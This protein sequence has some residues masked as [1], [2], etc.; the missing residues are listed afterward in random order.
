MPQ[1]LIHC[2]VIG[3]SNRE[4]ELQM[5]QTRSFIGYSD[6]DLRVVSA[7]CSEDQAHPVSHLK[8]LVYLAFGRS[9]FLEGFERFFV[10]CTVYV[11]PSEVDSAETNIAKQGL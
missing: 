9:S 1:H 6:H 11:G 3:E 8:V 5:F 4:G 2:H 10:R 7:L